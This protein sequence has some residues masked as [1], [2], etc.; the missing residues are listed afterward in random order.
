METSLFTLEYYITE[1]GKIPFKDWLESLKDIHARAKI[2]V[3]LD[4]VRLGNFGHAKFIGE[5]IN[6]LKIDFGPGYRVYYALAGDVIVLLLL[7][8]DKASQSKDIVRAKEYWKEFKR[9]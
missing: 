9:R 5:G 8:G 4:R 3:A 7:G 2:R 6:E 1:T